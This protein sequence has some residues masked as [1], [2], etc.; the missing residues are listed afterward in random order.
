VSSYAEFLRELEKRVGERAADLTSQIVSGAAVRDIE[1]Y[2][3][4]VGELRGLAS[5]EQMIKDATNH[6]NQRTTKT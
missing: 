1:T 2:R 3:E 6:V 4:R 5:V